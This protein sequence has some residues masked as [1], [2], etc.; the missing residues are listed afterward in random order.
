MACHLLRL[1][2]PILV[3]KTIDPGKLA[4]VIGHK[5]ITER[6]RLSRNEEIIRADRFATLLKTRSEQAISTIGGRVERQ[7]FKSTE[8]SSE[9][10]SKAW[11][12]FFFAAIT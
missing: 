1:Q 4:L 6:N 5:N 8:D 11:G 9:L 7:D 3:S 2:Q 10:C 12:S